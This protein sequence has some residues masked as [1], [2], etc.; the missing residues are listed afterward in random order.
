MDVSTDIVNDPK[1]RRLHRQN[2]EHVVAGFLAY[3]A[4]LGES[5]KAG[6]RCL[7][8]DAWPVIL[9]YDEA[10][11]AAMVAAELLDEKGQI[12][13]KTWTGWFGPAQKRRKNTRDRWKRAN[14]KKAETSTNNSAPT[15]QEPR[16]NHAATVAIPSVSQSVSQSDPPAPPVDAP[17]SLECEPALDAYQRFYVSPSRDALCFLDELAAEFGQEWT[18]RAIGEAGKE[19]RGKLLSRAKGLL[20]LWVRKSEKDEAGA[21]RDRNAAKRAPVHFQ[22][23]P[24]ETAEERERRETAYQAMRGQVANIGLP[25][26][27]PRGDA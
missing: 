25:G 13:A 6:R 8:T 14:D 24:E 19:G 12:P 22:P 21:E 10:A 2:P 3:V 23:R 17:P 20:I 15:A 26:A 27:K 1:F 7:I 4:I 18:A 16:G 11:I 5:W 9:P